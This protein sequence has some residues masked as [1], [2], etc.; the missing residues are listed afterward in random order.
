MVQKKAISIVTFPL[1]LRWP[2]AT[3]RLALIAGQWREA[4]DEYEATY[5]TREELWWC[6]AVMGVDVEV[7]V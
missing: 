4:G 7:L 6:L 2:A 5:R 3:E 1:R